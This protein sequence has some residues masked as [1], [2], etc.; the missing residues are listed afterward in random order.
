MSYTPTGANN[1]FEWSVEDGEVESPDHIEDEEAYMDL[2]GSGYDHLEIL[3]K[4]DVGGV[5]TVGSGS[6]S[7]TTDGS[8]SATNGTTTVYGGEMPTLPGS[9]SMGYAVAGGALVAVL[10]VVLVAAGGE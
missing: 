8:D 5:S 2:L 1:P 9:P 10:L 4:T 3:S 7:N 6:T